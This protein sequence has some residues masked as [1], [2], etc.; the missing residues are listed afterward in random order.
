MLHLLHP[1]NLVCYVFIFIYFHIFSSL[2]CH[3]FFDH[4]FKCILFTFNIFVGFPVLLLHRSSNLF[5]LWLERIVYIISI[6]SNLLRMFLWL[7]S[8]SVMD[9]VPCT[10]QNTCVLLLGIVFY[11]FLLDQLVFS[12]VQVLSFFIDLFVWYIIESKVL[13]YSTIIILLSISLFSSGQCLLH[14]FGTLM[15]G[16]NIL[17]IVI[18]ASNLKCILSVIRIATFVIF[19]FI[20]GMEFLS[21]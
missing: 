5:L 20:I 18:M 21:P 8:W 19:C 12:G 17:I 14:I 9:K 11:I 10:L 7:L 4:W 2:P 6:F 15:L 13:R 3:F 16:T 1:I